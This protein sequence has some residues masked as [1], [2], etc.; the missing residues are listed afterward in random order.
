MKKIY[1]MMGLITLSTVVVSCSNDDNLQQD[2]QAEQK[3][4]QA[5]E[6]LTTLE[7]KSF[8]DD[9]MSD[10]GDFDLD[11]DKTKREGKGKGK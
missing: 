1:F 7:V 6:V 4:K 10:R 11:K 3:E 2:I 8:S 5:Q 9:N